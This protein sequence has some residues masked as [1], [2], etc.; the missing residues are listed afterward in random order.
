M[1]FKQFVSIVTAFVFST[2]MFAFSV[3]GYSNYPLNKRDKLIGIEATG[4]TSEGGGIGL[5]SRFTYKPSRKIVLDM[6]L[7]TST[8]ERDGRIFANT[9][10]EIYPD[11]IRQPKFSLQVGLQNNN[12]YNVR[13]T[14]LLFSPILSKGFSI[15]NQEIFPFLAVPTGIALENDSKTYQSFMNINA[16]LTGKLPF[17]GY[18]HLLGT[19]EGSINLRNSYSGILIGIS[20]P[21]L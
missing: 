6:G 8:G 20:Y 4:V 3:T 5:Q 2:P 1:R 14:K 11:Y 10:Y 13:K 19:I 15:R 16:G 7:G 17:R 9:E 21:M 18:E 12:E